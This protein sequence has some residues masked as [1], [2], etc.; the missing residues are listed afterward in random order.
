MAKLF[1]AHLRG[2]G[3]VFTHRTRNDVGSISIYDSFDAMQP[4]IPAE[5]FEHAC[6]LAGLRKPKQ[7]PEVPLDV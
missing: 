6:E 4:N 3:F 1:G 7:Y 5:V 2:N